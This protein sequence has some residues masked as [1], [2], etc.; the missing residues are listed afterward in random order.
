M[1]RVVLD[2][3]III[4]AT[5]WGGLPRTI[6]R[7]GIQDDYQLLTSSALIDELRQT[8]HKP[9]FETA[10]QRLNQTPETILN[11]YIN[12]AALIE[13]EAISPGGL[14]D[15][16]DAIVLVCALSGGAD[17]IVSGDNDL[18]VLQTY[19]DI[20]IVTVDAFLKVLE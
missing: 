11:L 3:N 13:P 4:S 10:F 9:K 17:Y 5:F 6:Y 19:R 12:T 15:P 2:T 8:L 16:D 1:L 7:M 20:P 14:R 18:L